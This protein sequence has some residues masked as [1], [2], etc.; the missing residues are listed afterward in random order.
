MSV[1]FDNYESIVLCVSKKKS[2]HIFMQKSKKL[3]DVCKENFRK[4]RRLRGAFEE[5]VNKSEKF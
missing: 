3:L 1:E 5:N 4:Q 2:N